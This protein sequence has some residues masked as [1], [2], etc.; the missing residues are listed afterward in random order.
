MPVTS[1]AQAEA[2]QPSNF[3]EW[4][5]A[6]RM[7]RKLSITEAAERAGWKMQFWSGIET[8]KR[9]RKDGTPPVPE[10]ETVKTIARVLR[11]EEDI[12]LLAAGHAPERLRQ[13]V[14]NEAP[15]L[16]GRDWELPEQVGL[17]MPLCLTP[18]PELPE[19]ELP[20]EL[21]SLKER[22]QCLENALERAKLM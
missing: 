17:P 3:A 7:F 21:Q 9:P 16:V 15:T 12:A 2:I 6:W 5:R 1:S 4:I 14:Y 20:S 13:E 19:D 18:A 11:V 22:V 8:M 10:R